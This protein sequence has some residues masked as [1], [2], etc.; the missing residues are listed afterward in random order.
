MAI[1]RYGFTFLSLH[2][3][4]RSNRPIWAVRALR[5]SFIACRAGSSGTM[6]RSTRK[7]RV[8][9]SLIAPWTVMLSVRLQ[10][11]R[12]QPTKSHRG[13][14][15]GS[16]PRSLPQG[17]GRRRETRRARSSAKLL[18]PCLHD[19]LLACSLQKE[20]RSRGRIWGRRLEHV[21]GCQVSFGARPFLQLSSDSWIAEAKA[22]HATIRGLAV[23]VLTSFSNHS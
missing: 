15:Q 10:E 14:S 1:A 4:V 21:P 19:T 12:M 13:P 11:A 8:W 20:T 22:R 23:V 17:I 6:T 2:V 3:S 5:R 7:V 9:E 18:A 16:L